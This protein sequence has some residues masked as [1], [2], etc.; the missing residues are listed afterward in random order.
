ME[1]HITDSR[2]VFSALSLLLKLVHIFI[3]RNVP[4]VALYMS[5]LN[6]VRSLMVKAP[7]F[8]VHDSARKPSSSS[9]LPVLT[10][11]GNLLAGAFVSKLSLVLKAHVALIPI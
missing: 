3:I 9:A 2:E 11:Q 5:S 10:I 8:A 7:F 4:G 1:R 6:H